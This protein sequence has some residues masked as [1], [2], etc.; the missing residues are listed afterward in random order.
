[1]VV[2]GPDLHSGGDGRVAD[3]APQVILRGQEARV[4]TT[5]TSIPQR[6]K[7][8][9]VRLFVCESEIPRLEEEKDILRPWCKSEHFKAV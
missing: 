1:M 8:D 5:T 4:M 7:E 2:P 6:E 9:K 3:E